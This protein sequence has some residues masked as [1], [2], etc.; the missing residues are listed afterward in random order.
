MSYFNYIFIEHVSGAKVLFE[1]PRQ[2]HCQLLWCSKRYLVT[3]IL[4]KNKLVLCYLKC[5]ITRNYKFAVPNLTKSLVLT[6]S[7][8]L[9][10][11]AKYKFDQIAF[12]ESYQN[13]VTQIKSLN[14]FVNKQKNEVHWKKNKENLTPNYLFKKV[15]S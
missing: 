12:S 10:F 8:W 1:F 9:A 6:S 11:I 5:Y 7:Q 14:M 3:S 15:R 13:L 2:S 4:H